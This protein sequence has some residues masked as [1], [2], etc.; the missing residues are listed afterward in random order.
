MNCH[1]SHIELVQGVSDVFFITNELKSLETR[2]PGIIPYMVQRTRTFVSSV[3]ILAWGQGV[4]R[5]VELQLMERL[6][7]CW[8]AG[9]CIQLKLPLKISGIAHEI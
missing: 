9:K 8:E 7:P 4:G 5:T 1:C 3:D 2:S 6:K